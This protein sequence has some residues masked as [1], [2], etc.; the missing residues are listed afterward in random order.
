MKTIHW[1]LHGFT[2]CG[3]YVPELPDGN[4]WVRENEWMPFS[5]EKPQKDCQKC[6]KC[7]EEFKKRHNAG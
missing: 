7:D 6:V 3:A 2:G 4:F 1:I 5:M